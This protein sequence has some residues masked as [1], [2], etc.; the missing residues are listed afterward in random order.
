MSTQED[1][2]R[3]F[4]RQAAISWLPD[5][6]KRHLSPDDTLVRKVRN[7]QGN[8]QDGARHTQSDTIS[9]LVSPAADPAANIT[10]S[11]SLPLPDNTALV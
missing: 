1:I 5:H 6:L 3:S 11:K 2:N 10:E 4:I 9:I 7:T 8:I